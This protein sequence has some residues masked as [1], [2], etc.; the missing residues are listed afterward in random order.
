MQWQTTHLE[1]TAVSE[2]LLTHVAVCL[3]SVVVVVSVLPAVLNLP[4]GLE[5]VVSEKISSKQVAL[6]CWLSAEGTTL[7]PPFTISNHNCGPTSS[8]P[9]AFC[10][11]ICP[12]FREAL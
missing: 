2:C 10:V 7:I 11:F 6:I 5:A 9:W 12:P 3:L 1:V 8:L 4:H